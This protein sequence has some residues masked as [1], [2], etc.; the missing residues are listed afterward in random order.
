MIPLDEGVMR[1]LGVTRR[2]R[3]Q[4]IL[5]AATPV[6]GCSSRP[7]PDDVVILPKHYSRWNIEPIYFIGENQIDF[8][9][10]NIIKYLMRA[11]FKH[12]S[13]VEDHTKAIRYAVMRC[14]K[15]IGDP[16]WAGDYVSN[17]KECLEKEFAHER[18]PKAG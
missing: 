16:N 2:E 7:L 10:G 8:L 3:K 13:P 14:K 6:K 9:L 12:A 5:E 11:E 18:L 1:T 15:L 4:S 17:L